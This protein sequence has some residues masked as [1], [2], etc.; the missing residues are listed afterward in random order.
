[1]DITT[2]LYICRKCGKQKKPTEEFCQAC[3]TRL[4]VSTPSPPEKDL[5]RSCP[6]CGTQIRPSARFCSQCGTRL[7]KLVDSQTVASTPAQF[8]NP[9]LSASLQQKLAERAKGQEKNHRSSGG[10]LP[11]I[12]PQAITPI[13]NSGNK[14]LSTPKVKR[15]VKNI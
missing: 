11:A 1:M 14:V 12:I 13:Q 10:S 5:I 6:N 2:Y 4:P 9:H 7:Q 3:L 15:V 8:S